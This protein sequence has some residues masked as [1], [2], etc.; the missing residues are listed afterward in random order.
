MVMKQINVNQLQNQISK[1]V[2]E[3]EAGEIY[4]VSRYSK[5][6]AYLLPE[7]E[8]E[9]AV[10]GSGCKACMADLRKITKALNGRD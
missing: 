6:V 10:S 3:V 9:A 1:I 4:Q 2:R 5:P 7:E 8:F